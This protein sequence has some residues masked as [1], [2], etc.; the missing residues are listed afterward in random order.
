MLS[1]IAVDPVFEL[2]EISHSG[3]F[4]N[5]AECPRIDLVMERNDN[6]S[7]IAL[8]VLGWLPSEDC[9][10]AVRSNMRENSTVY[11]H[12]LHFDT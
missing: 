4:S 11:H 1:S 2:L 7:G 3:L 6:R 9:V 8:V 10:I 5:I 12:F